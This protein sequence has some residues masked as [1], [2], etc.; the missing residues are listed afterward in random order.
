LKDLLE[1][2][3]GRVPDGVV[4]IEGLVDYCALLID[5][6]GAGKG[7]AVPG[8]VLRNIGVQNAELADDGTIDI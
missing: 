1:H 8:M 5:H 2:P 7:N 4:R 6:E 3:P